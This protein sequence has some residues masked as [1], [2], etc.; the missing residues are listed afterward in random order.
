MKEHE[1]Q[2]AKSAVKFYGSVENYTEK[3][4]E[5]LEHF[6]ERMEKLEELKKSNYLQRN[7]KLYQLLL[8][9][10]TKDVKSDEIQEIVGKIIKISDEISKF[11]NMDLPENYWNATIERYLNNKEVIQTIDKIYAVGVSKFMGSALAYYFANK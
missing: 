7:T 11:T 2:I 6:P 8:K 5:N 3:M 1:E 4:K 10:I 9:D